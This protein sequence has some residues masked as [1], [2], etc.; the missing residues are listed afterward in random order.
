M[1][2]WDP[3]KIRREKDTQEEQDYRDRFNQFKI[4]QRIKEQRKN[5]E[6]IQKSKVGG[7]TIGK[8]PTEKL[9]V[10]K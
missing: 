10:G 1:V 6:A 8:T 7:D 9:S 5:E 2:M 3:A 4:I